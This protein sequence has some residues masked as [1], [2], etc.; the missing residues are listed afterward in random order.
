M[1]ETFKKNFSKPEG[2]YGAIAGK[3]MAWENKTINEWAIV[4]LNLK[5]GEHILEVGF[6]PGYSMEQLA[7]LEEGVF[8]ADS[9]KKGTKK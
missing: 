6:G 5:A 3:I 4:H 8:S 1:L 9:D 2:V 7:F